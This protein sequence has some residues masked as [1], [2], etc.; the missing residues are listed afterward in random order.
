MILLVYHD[1]RRL[2]EIQSRAA[3]HSLRQI[4]PSKLLA[5]QV[6]LVEQQPVGRRHLVHAEQHPVRQGGH[7]RQCI[8]HLRQDAQP[9][10]IPR[11]TRERIA[12]DVSREADARRQHDIGVVTR[13]V[14]PA[15]P[16]VRK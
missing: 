9:L 11:P 4:Q 13:G 12:F 6:P 5:D 15:R 7:L 10:S 16:A 14:E 3:S 1:A 2:A 8:P